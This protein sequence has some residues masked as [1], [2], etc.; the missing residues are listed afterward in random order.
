MIHNSPIWIFVAAAFLSTLG[1]L[2]YLLRTTEGAITSR[3]VFTYGLNTG[4][5]GLALCMVWYSKFQDQIYV[6]IGLCMFVGLMGPAGVEWLL[7]IVKI[8]VAKRIDQELKNDKP[9]A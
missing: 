9:N 5:A 2:A 3:K 8:I 1:G 7:S 6:L 4:L